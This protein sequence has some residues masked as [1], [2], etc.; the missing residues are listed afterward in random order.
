MVKHRD[1]LWNDNQLLRD[2]LRAHP[3]VAA[4]YSRAKKQA[5]LGGARTLLGY[6][7]AKAGEMTTLL[8][9]ARRWSCG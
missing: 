4:A 9:N 7:E 1:R 6:S 3:S 5:W 2:Y 8:E